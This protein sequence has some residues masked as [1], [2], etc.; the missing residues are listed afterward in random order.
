MAHTP[1]SPSLASL[2]GDDKGEIET[3]D[4]KIGTVYTQNFQKNLL[5]GIK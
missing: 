5:L 1:G 2:A 4:D 3:G